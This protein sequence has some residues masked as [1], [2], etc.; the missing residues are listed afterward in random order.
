MFTLTSQLLMRCLTGASDFAGVVT[1][2]IDKHMRGVYGH[3]ALQKPDDL[4]RYI[5]FDR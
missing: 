3:V 5:K 2:A 4:V 1:E